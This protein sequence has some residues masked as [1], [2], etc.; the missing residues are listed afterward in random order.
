MSKTYAAKYLTFHEA[1][2]M[3]GLEEKTLRQW[4]RAGSGP[5]WIKMGSAVMYLRYEVQ[6][7]IEKRERMKT[8][9]NR[10]GE[11]TL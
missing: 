2:L 3:I 10:Q 7:W 1:A 9:I 11:L 6:A 8:A 5:A 4:Q